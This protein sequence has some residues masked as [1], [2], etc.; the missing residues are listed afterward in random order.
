M[1]YLVGITGMCLII[2]GW[3]FSIEDIPPLKL[4]ILYSIGSF[5]L[6]TYAYLLNDVLFLSLNNMATIV[7]FVNVIRALKRTYKHST[8]MSWEDLFAL[9]YNRVSGVEREVMNFVKEHLKDSVTH[10]LEH[11]MRVYNLSLRIAREYFHRGIDVDMLVLKLAA[12]LHDVGRPL[13]KELGEHHALLSAEVAKK[14]LSELNLENEVIERVCNA[15]ESHSFSL[16]IQPMSIEAKILSDADKLDAIG[17]IG[18]SRCFMLAGI[19]KRS[20]A[21]SV[22]HFYEKLLKLKD[23]MFTD[24]AREIAVPRHEFM[25]R[26][27]EQ[28]KKELSESVMYGD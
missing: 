24:V 17:A 5:L 15:I 20:I 27:L 2:L 10:G 28:L 19:T 8:S 25:E 14:L 22:K 21:E 16:G 13:E 11:T 26:F 3:I 4:S 18:I 6:A 12:L 1:N 23:M 7:S 9:Q